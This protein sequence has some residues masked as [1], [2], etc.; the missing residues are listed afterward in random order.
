M[1]ITSDCSEFTFMLGH[2][3]KA[4]LSQNIAVREYRLCL[5][6]NIKRLT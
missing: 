4:L 6:E 3:I 2:I 1:P 5:Q